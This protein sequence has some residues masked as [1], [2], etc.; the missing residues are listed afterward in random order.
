TYG[1]FAP[2]GRVLALV[3]ESDGAARPVVVLAPAGG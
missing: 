3:A 2:D 1:V